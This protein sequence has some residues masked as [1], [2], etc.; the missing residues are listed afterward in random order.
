MRRTPVYAT[1]RNRTENVWITKDRIKVSAG[2]RTVAKTQAPDKPLKD[3]FWFSLTRS[4]VAD[5]TARRVLNVKAHPYYLGSVPLGPN[6]TRTGSSPAKV[7]IPFDSWLRY[8]SVAGSILT[9]KLCSRLLMVFGQHFCEKRQIWV[10]KPHFGEV[11][12]DARPWLMAR[13]KA[14]GRPSV[15]VKWAF[16]AICRFRSYEAKCVQLGCLHKV[17]YMDR[18]VPHQPFLASEN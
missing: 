10:S 12:G 14:H 8:N 18:V 5:C 4:A 3:A 2:P 11:K 9:M 7:L 16:F 6:F 13:W 17:F 15:C 1:K